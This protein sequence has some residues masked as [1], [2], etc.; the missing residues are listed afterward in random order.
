MS[1]KLKE[2]A[3]QLISSRFEISEGTFIAVFEKGF[4]DVTAVRNYMIREEAACIC[5]NHTKEEAIEILAK[6]NYITAQNKE[7]ET[8][9]TEHYPVFWKTYYR[10][11]NTIDNPENFGFNTYKKLLPG[12]SAIKYSYKNFTLSYGTEN[13]WWGPGRYNAL[14]LS[15]NAAGFAHAALSSNAPIKTKMGNIR[16]FNFND[17]SDDNGKGFDSTSYNAYLI[18]VDS[19]M[20][21]WQFN[22][23]EV[24]VRNI[25]D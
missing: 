5:H 7:F 8:F 3:A 22:S 16:N 17:L 20:F 23:N 24:T 21:A 6:P 9:P 2:R 14:I 25:L 15:N 13:R 12:Q 18:A 11:L 10:W 4:I 1:D 19:L